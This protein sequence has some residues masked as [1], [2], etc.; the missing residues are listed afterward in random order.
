MNKRALAIICF[1]FVCG[2]FLAA[3]ET[4][5]LH[6][7]RYDGDYDGWGLHVWGDGY[8]G[9]PVDWTKPMLQAGT[10]DYG[11]FW[12]IPWNGTG[13]INFIIHKG[14]AKDPDGDRV[15]PDPTKNRE[16][17]AVTDDP[18]T[19][20]TPKEAEENFVGAISDENLKPETLKLHYFRFDGNYAGWGLHVWGT[21]YDGSEMQW[22]NPLEP[23]GTS[24]T[25]V[26]WDIPYRGAG[27]IKY[28]IHNG[29]A[30]DPDGDRF[31]P[32]P[33]RNKE[34]WSITED[35]TTY[36]TIEEAKKNMGNKIIRAIL[37][38]ESQIEVEFRMPNDRPI[39]VT[40][41]GK[42]LKVEK[43]EETSDNVYRITTAESLDI[44]TSYIIESGDMSTGTSV[45]WQ[46]IDG[47]YTYD[48]DLGCF[49]SPELTAFKLWAPLASRITLNLYKNGSDT[50]PYEKTAMIRIE[51]GVWQAFIARDI[52]KEFYNYSVV[53]GNE[54][55]VV[56]DPYA[57]SMAANDGSD[58]IGKGAVVNTEA[59]GPKLSYADIPGYTKREDA[60]IWEVHVRDFT[61]DPDIQTEAQFG[62][63]KAFIE[64][65]DYL[66][67]LGVTHVQLLPVM[68]YYFG[69]ETING[70][71]EDEYSTQGNNYNWGY[72]PHN[73]FSPE[74]MYSCD[75]TDP[76]LRIEELKTL[77][78]AIHERGMGVILDCVYNHTAKMS[79][80]EDIVP[81]YY[82]FMDAQGNPK[83]S[84]GGGRPG[85]THAMTRKLV[86]DS[87]LHW[88]RE[89]KVDGFRYDLMGDLDAETVQM[90][91]DQSK[92]LNPN[93]IYVGEGWRTY[94]GD[95]GDPRTPADQDWM[96]QTSA[97]A[98]FSDEIRN[99]LKSGFGSEGQPRFITGGA[100]SIDVIF[101]NICGRPG[102]STADEP[103][104][105][106]QYIAAHD[107]LTLHDVI[108]QSIR[109]DPAILQNEFD[110][111]L[112]IRLGNT[113]ILT[114]QG[115]AFLHAGQEYGRTKQWL[116]DTTP[117][118]SATNVPGFHHSW[119]V[120]NSYDSSDIINKFDWDKVEKPGMHRTTMEYT[121]GLIEL[122]RSTD[123]FRL[124]D[125][126]LVRSNVKRIQSGNIKPNDL[127]IAYTC[128]ATDGTDYH[129]IVNCDSRAREFGCGI[130][131]KK[132]TVIVDQDEAGTTEV[133]K[134]KGYTFESNSKI[135]LDPL[136]AVIIKM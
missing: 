78:D 74:G 127:L 6:Y 97:A 93:I 55:K 84:Y 64:K 51:K 49:Y 39:S 69:N 31:W 101:S 8:F 22:T 45:S 12:N 90:A 24:D 56:L 115:I 75:P 30:K 50:E 68:S 38:G 132:G 13:T 77:I 130:D 99:E 126:D 10:D 21:G 94:T 43:I 67:R 106:V 16:A 113:L 26:Y 136:T 57:K 123:A 66:E 17:W 37:T 9:Q 109:K 28:I 117:P 131:L 7:H 73:Y 112:R 111:Q 83:S 81:G 65:L 62:T 48:G 70:I 110:I 15:F 11:V 20:P 46:S 92:A 80:L 4:L 23:S 34:A 98:C 25:G 29:D 102:N 105:V 40:S 121:R 79:I 119:F 3:E 91:Y 87:I 72:D 60:I 103:G 36:T 71:R 118:S 88:V 116:A 120:D 114:S 59:I 89:Y 47:L 104:D 124:G 133:K 82:H 33:A 32:S 14:D 63:Y 100:R 129:V 122:R 107:N 135:V 54:E 95:D 2:S 134:P 58:P 27:S 108:A 35:G 41:D 128:T 53:N 19:Y 96:N 5:K 44:A 52:R 1:V 125:A 86:L 85:T 61:S 18:M 76:E 42:S